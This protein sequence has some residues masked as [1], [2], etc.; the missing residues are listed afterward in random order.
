MRS[1]NNR[2]HELIV[3]A[4]GQVLRDGYSRVLLD[5]V[6]K[7]SGLKKGSLYY[8][9]SSKEDL[10]CEIIKKYE[11]QIKQTLE[12]FSVLNPIE[13]IG[14]YFDWAFDLASDRSKFS[15]LSILTPEI[16]SLPNTM[17][18]LLQSVYSFENGWL[19]KAIKEGQTEKIFRK[20]L[21][22]PEIADIVMAQGIGIQSSAHLLNSAEVIKHAKQSLL[23]LLC[24]KPP[25]V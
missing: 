13:R 17:R 6:C 25:A 7:A 23:R 16:N 20:D 4:L 19:T 10:G 8:F 14:R 21:S 24:E 9:I 12:S 5:D 11:S 1:S 15:L 3:S 22:A 2:K 18:Q